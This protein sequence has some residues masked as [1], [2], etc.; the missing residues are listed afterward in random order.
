M[1]ERK[2]KDPKQEPAWKRVLHAMSTE[3]IG[4]HPR[5]HAYNALARLLPIGSGEQRAALFRGM[6]FKLGRGARI[7]GQLHVSG[8]HGLMSRLTIGSDVSIGPDCVFEL[9]ERLTIGDRVT[10]EPGV[11]ILTTTH[12]LDV[13]DHRAGPLTPAPVAIGDGVWLRARCMVL[14]GVK[15]GAGAVIEAGAVVNK[16]VA[17]NTRVAGIPAAPVET[18]KVD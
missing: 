9:S 18:L 10:I 4:V 14:P 6:G 12:E 15:V 2:R 13:A 7:D 3:V 5:L 17:P 8:P 11:M 1:S 16:D